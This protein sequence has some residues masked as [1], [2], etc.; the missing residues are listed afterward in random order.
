MPMIARTQKIKTYVINWFLA[1]I[2][3]LHVVG[4]SSRRGIISGGIR[5]C[6][7]GII[8]RCGGG[9]RRRCRGI[10]GSCSC[11]CRCGSCVVCRVFGVIW[12]VWCGWGR[13]LD[14]WLVRKSWF[15]WYVGIWRNV[16]WWFPFCFDWWR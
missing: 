16:S 14:R 13:E 10:G 6:G 15:D 3:I 8:C 2:F 1:W 4:G 7:C 5:R 9:R 11:V 12:L